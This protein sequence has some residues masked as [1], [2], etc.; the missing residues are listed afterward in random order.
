MT[1]RLTALAALLF[2]LAG[3]FSAS[4]ARAAAQTDQQIADAA[5]AKLQ[6]ETDKCNAKIISTAEA[7]IVKINLQQSK[8]AKP[9]TVAATAR[10]AKSSI[11]K[12]NT[13]GNKAVDKA[14]ATA[15]KTLQKRHADQALID[16]VI[17]KHTQVYPTLN[18]TATDCFG[19]IDNALVD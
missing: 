12:T 6:A 14:A 10:S 17:A 16:A 18:A 3:L 15:I 11:V 19:A 13:T 2:A 7:A 9:A 4:T 5:I 1:R 8:N